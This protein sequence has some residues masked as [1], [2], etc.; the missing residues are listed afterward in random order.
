M[1]HITKLLL[2]LIVVV[3][4]TRGAPQPSAL[5]SHVATFV[6]DPAT[7]GKVDVQLVCSPLLLSRLSPSPL[8]SPYPLLFS[9]M[10]FLPLSYLPLLVPLRA[11]WQPVSLIMLP[12]TNYSIDMLSFFL[13]PSS[14]PSL[15]FLFSSSRASG[16][17]RHIIIA[18]GTNNHMLLLSLPTTHTHCAACT[19][20]DASRRTQHASRRTQHASRITHHITLTSHPNKQTLLTYLL[21]SSICI[22]IL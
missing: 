3:G 20:E 6:I 12:K 14:P 22:S 5:Q 1:Q 17:R 10:L 18:P 4:Y 21:G 19:K 8:S 2:L 15:P 9:L 11:M 16:Y 7:K 13:S